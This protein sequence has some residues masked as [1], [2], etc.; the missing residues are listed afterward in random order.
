MTLAH[1]LDAITGPKK[2]SI[3]RARLPPTCPRNGC[4][5][6][7]KHY[8]RGRINHRCINHRFINHRCINHRCINHRCINSYYCLTVYCYRLWKYKVGYRVVPWLSSSSFQSPMSQPPA[9]SCFSSFL[10]TTVCSFS[11]G[12]LASAAAAQIFSF[13]ILSCHALLLTCRVGNKNPNQKTHPKK[14]KN[15]KNHLKNPLK[16]FFF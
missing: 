3:S 11:A 4:C 9:T 12:F 8:A 16:C 6:H 2:V 13:C 14:P 5:P 7:Q 10:P 15:P 1:W